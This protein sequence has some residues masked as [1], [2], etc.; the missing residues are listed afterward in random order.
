M[1]IVYKY[2][3]IYINKLEQYKTKGIG[4][5]AGVA[6]ARVFPAGNR[7]ARWGA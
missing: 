6:V 4:T 3:K 2:I 1:Q 7:R 5:P